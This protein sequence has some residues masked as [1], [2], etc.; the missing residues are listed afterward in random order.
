MITGQE[1]LKQTLE[2]KESAM[3]W[4]RCGKKKCIEREREDLTVSGTRDV[5]WE[6]EQ[7]NCNTW[8]D[9]QSDLEP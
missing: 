2:G 1:E 8:L 4:R 6:T 7:S 5:C 3:R 9:V